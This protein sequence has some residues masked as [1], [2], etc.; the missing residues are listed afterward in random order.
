MLGCK[1]VDFCTSCQVWSHFL[2]TTIYNIRHAKIFAMQKVLRSVSTSSFIF[3]SILIIACQKV[4]EKSADLITVLIFIKEKK[5]SDQNETIF[6][7]LQRKKHWLTFE[8][9]IRFSVL[10]FAHIVCVSWRAV[11]VGICRWERKREWVTDKEEGSCE[12][13]VFVKRIVY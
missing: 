10:L 3:A 6:F 12:H 5:L 7:F 2:A 13:V 9:L 1:I 4:L 11:S 8:R